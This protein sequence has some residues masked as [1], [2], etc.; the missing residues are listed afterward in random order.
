MELS[1]IITNYKNAE[2]LKV[3]ID[4]IKKNLTLGDVEIIVADSE[5]EEGTEMMMR[6]DYPQITFIPSKKNI[7][8]EGTVK[9]GYEKSHGDYVLILNGDIIVKKDSIEKLLDHIKQDP[10]VGMVGPKLLNFNETLQFSCFRFYT[11]MTIVYRRTYLGKL[12]FAKKKLDRFLMRDFDHKSAVDVDWLMGSA[13]MTKRS[14]IEKVGLMDSQFKLYL[15]DTDWCRR[16]W[17]NGYRVVYYPLAEMYHYHGRGSASKSV[18][19][20]LASN[21]LAWIHINSAIKYFIKY[22]GKPNPRNNQ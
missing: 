14:A 4:S 18:L 9:N 15:E 13:I 5:T 7:G 6:E 11:P 20:A 12:G 1:I 10:K 3:C 21:K 22:A 8:F 19:K 16:F 2:L 17:E